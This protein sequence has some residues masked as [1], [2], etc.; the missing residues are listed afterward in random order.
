[1]SVTIFVDA[2]SCPKMVRTYL[3]SYSKKLNLKII[4]AANKNIPAEDAGD[5]FS[6]VICSKE[7]QAA[8]LFIMNNATGNDI[9]ITRDIPLA[10]ELIKKE[11]VTINDRGDVFTKENIKRKLSE[12]ELSIAISGM[13]MGFDKSR[14]VRYSYS[15]KEFSQF[16]NCFDREIHRLINKASATPNQDTQAE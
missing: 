9:V 13:G 11:I 10:D 5:N 14:T 16:A 6:M 4:F 3:L 7:S 8:D 15:T 12:R 1:M 2:D